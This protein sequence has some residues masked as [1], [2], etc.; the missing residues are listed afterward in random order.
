MK[1]HQIAVAAALC[2]LVCANLTL[3]QHED[4]PIV[5]HTFNGEYAQA[6]ALIQKATQQDPNNPRYYYLRANL[7]F[8][9]RYFGN[10]ELSTA[11]LHE[12]VAQNARKAVELAENLEQTPDNRFY[13]GSA[14][15]LLSRVS[16]LKDRSVYDAYSF[17]RDSKNTLEDLLE[18]N[19]NYHDAKV[20]LA[21]LDYFAATRLTGWWQETIAWVTGMSGNK[22]AALND[23]ELVAQKGNLCKAE[24]RFILVALYRFFEQEPTKVRTYLTGFMHDYPQNIFANNIYHRIQLEDLIQEHGV[25]FLTVHIDS[26]KAEYNINSDAVLNT[27]GYGFLGNE[28]FDNAIAVFRLNVRLFPEAANCYD[29]LA[30]AYMTSGQNAEAVKNYRIALEKVDSD[31]TR[32]EAARTSL[33]ENIAQQLDRLNAT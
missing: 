23:L 5:F 1:S 27:V 12:L 7:A 18:D 25:A 16:F 30:E 22:E 14:Y 31:T 10:T 15:G 32:N 11:E 13:L 28:E 3:A 21:V 6:E 4:D 9:A 29:S 26:L 19:P 20:G 8:Y 2:L 33:R 17:A 24:A